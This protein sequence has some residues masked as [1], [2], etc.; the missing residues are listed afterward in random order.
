[1]VPCFRINHSVVRGGKEETVM[2]GMQAI[3]ARTPQDAIRQ[4]VAEIRPDLGALP[5]DDMIDTY[6]QD[7]PSMIYAI[8]CDP[9]TLGPFPNGEIHLP[10][11]KLGRNIKDE[12]QFTPEQKMLLIGIGIGL[13][14]G[15]LVF[16]I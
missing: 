12:P 5:Y 2:F 13:A 6:H 10:T 4:Y 8:E 11:G 15:V 7:R 16:A 9:D 3:E 14:I 1:M